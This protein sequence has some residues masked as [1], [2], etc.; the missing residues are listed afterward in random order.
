[1]SNARKWNA[2][3]AEFR[4]KI[5]GKDYIILKLSEYLVG[6][7]ADE[8]LLEDADEI[9]E[10][11]FFNEEEWIHIYEYDGEFWMNVIKDN[12]AEYKNVEFILRSSQTLVCRKPIAYDNYGQA[13]FEYMRPVCIV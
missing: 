11:H 13:Y 10:A 9:M 12:G 4:K 7:D 1:M 5:Q 2:N 6:K 8:A 3:D